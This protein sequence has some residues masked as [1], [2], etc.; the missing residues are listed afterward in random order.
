MPTLSVEELVQKPAPLAW[1]TLTDWDNDHRWMPGIGGMKAG[2]ATVAG[3]KL[4]FRARG[5]ERSNTVIHCDVGRSIVLCSV[6]CAD[7]VADKIVYKNRTMLRGNT[8]PLRWN[9]L[10]H[11]H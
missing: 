4:T 2:A 10:G 9:L 11:V 3:T 7:A 1:E 8:W 5:V 6:R